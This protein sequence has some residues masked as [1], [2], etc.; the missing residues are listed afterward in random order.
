[1]R[2]NIVKKIMI[3]SF[4]VFCGSLTANNIDFI[5]KWRI[6]IEQTLKS[7]PR[8]SEK[9]TSYLKNYFGQVSLE[10]YKSGAFKQTINSDLSYEGTWDKYSDNF[11]VVR[12]GSDYKIAEA[13]E[14]LRKKIQNFSGDRRKNTRQRQALYNLNR[15]SVRYF[16]TDR[17]LIYYKHNFGRYES[18]IYFHKVN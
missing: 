9:Q 11:V 18:S 5:G 13:K 8:I 10:F 15:L 17:N 3:L 7:S 14:Q 1:M 16:S 12:C 6:D 2:F 4:F